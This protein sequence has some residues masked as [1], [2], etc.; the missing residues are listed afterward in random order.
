MS[1]V[2]VVLTR[3]VEY[4]ALML[5]DSGREESVVMLEARR[6]KNAG[7][8]IVCICNNYTEIESYCNSLV[9]ELLI[10]LNCCAVSAYEFFM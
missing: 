6:K 2:E 4:C 1:S 9:A 10:W 8:V 5:R 7:C 3:N